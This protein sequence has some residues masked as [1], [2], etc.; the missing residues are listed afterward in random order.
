MVT[1][2][3]RLQEKQ[4]QYL[5]KERQVPEIIPRGPAT[6]G[7]SAGPSSLL[8]AEKLLIG[9]INRWAKPSPHT[10]SAPIWPQL[11]PDRTDVMSLDRN[12]SSMRLAYPTLNGPW[13]RR[14]RKKARP[15]RAK[16]A[17]IRHTG[18]RARYL[19]KLCD[20]AAKPSTNQNDVCIPQ[21]QA[22]RF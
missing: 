5:E 20:C 17:K 4:P 14:A 8:Q 22:D 15:L 12:T 7:R 3:D 10:I 6:A 19:S 9:L 16:V 21:A 13:M 1:L 11:H 2:F 18:L